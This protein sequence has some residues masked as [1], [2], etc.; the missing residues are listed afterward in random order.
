VNVRSGTAANSFLE[1]APD[2][3]LAAEHP[4]SDEVIIDVV[5]LQARDGVEVAALEGVEDARSYLSR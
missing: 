2:R 1:E 4:D 5:V 3:G